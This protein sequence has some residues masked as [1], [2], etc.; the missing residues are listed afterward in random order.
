[1]LV[2]WEYEEALA[3]G[4]AP[5]THRLIDRARGEEV[6]VQNLHRVC[7]IHVTHESSDQTAVIHRITQLNVAIAG[8][9]KDGAIVTNSNAPNLSVQPIRLEALS[10][11]DVPYL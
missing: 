6:A 9:D 2:A 11:A 8:A 3:S 5:N 1:V 4:N 10:S 7:V